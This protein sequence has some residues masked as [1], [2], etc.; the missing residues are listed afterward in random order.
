MLLYGQLINHAL[1]C[2]HYRMTLTWPDTY[3]KR[4]SFIDRCKKLDKALAQLEVEGC[5]PP[6]INPVVF[7]CQELRVSQSQM[8]NAYS[9]S[10]DTASASTLALE[11]VSRPFGGECP[12]AVFACAGSSKPKFF[13]EMDEQDLLNGMTSAC[14][15]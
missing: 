4:R 13:V 3:P 12:D 7:F 15:V 10:L 9:H 5:Q 2:L 11:D 1:A 14:W 8:L 6:Y